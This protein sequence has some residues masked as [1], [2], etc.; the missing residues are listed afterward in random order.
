MLEINNKTNHK[1]RVGQLKLITEG[2]FRVYKKPGA[3]VSLA[4]VG[5]KRMR[6]LN[7]EYRG[8]DKSTDVLSFPALSSWKKDPE[9]YLGEII[10]N[11]EEAGKVKKYEEMLGELDILAFRSGPEVRNYLFNFLFVHGLLHL[12]GYSDQTAAGRR[13]MLRRGRDFLKKML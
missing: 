12:V 7:R 11:Q 8:I 1:V 10:I 2:F 9:R 3:T 4:I 6:R 5:S 13:E